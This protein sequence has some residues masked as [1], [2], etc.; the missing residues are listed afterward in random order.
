MR[1]VA[2]EFMDMQQS[3]PL[4]DHGGVFLRWSEGNAALMKIMI[5]PSSDTPY[6]GGCFEFDV[7]IPSE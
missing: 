4:S 7:C 6:G 5:I 1:R 3:L 2:Q